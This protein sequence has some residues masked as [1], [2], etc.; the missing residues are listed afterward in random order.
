MQNKYDNQNDECNTNFAMVFAQYHLFTAVYMQN[1]KNEFIPVNYT[2]HF[3][4]KTQ[5][6]KV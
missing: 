2:I 3:A 4:H 6:A 1:Y 5:S